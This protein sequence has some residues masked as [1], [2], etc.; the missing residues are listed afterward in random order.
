MTDLE[1]VLAAAQRRSE[2]LVHKDVEALLALLHPDFVY[3]NA[4]G[5][6]L[7]RDQYLDL[8]VRPVEVR[9]VSQSI[10]EPR[11]AEAAGAAVLTCLVRD[12]A[13]Y[14]DQ[15]MNETFRSTLTWIRTDDGWQC[16]AG[17]TSRPPVD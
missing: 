2:A 1:A 13:R 12:V 4:S 5:Q 9:W 10:E 3:V 15:E 7:D 6:V 14:Y 8:Y 17:H 11:I 16:L